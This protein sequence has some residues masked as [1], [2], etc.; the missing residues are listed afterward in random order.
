MDKLADRPDLPHQEVLTYLRCYR[1]VTVF[2][3]CGKEVNGV[4]STNI[5]NIDLEPNSIM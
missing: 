4:A 3:I 1:S 5:N 2:K